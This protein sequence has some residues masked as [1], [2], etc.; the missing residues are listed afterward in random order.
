MM[1]MQRRGVFVFTRKISCLSHAFSS[2]FPPLSP[3]SHKN[4]GQC[5]ARS[6]GKAKSSHFAGSVYDEETGEEA[7]F[8]DGLLTCECNWNG[9]YPKYRTTPGD[10]F[11]VPH[12]GER[13]YTYGWHSTE[14][15]DG[16]TNVVESWNQKEL[17]EV[18]CLHPS[19]SPIEIKEA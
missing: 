11:D 17:D 18:S 13:T 12:C 9:G 7:V 1:D 3:H 2:S 6:D 8:E 5:Q 16:T 14:T 4:R 19:F 10:A 15:G